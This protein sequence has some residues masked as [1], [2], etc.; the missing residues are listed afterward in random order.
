[1]QWC[2]DGDTMKPFLYSH[3]SYKSYLALMDIYGYL[4]TSKYLNTAKIYRGTH[5]YAF[6]KS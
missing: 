5:G 4:R 6:R 2:I 3:A 1:M